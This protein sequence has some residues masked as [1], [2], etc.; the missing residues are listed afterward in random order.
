MKIV[1][2]GGLGYIGSALVPKLAV[3]HQTAEIVV[4]DKRFVPERVADFPYPDRVRFVQGD[5]ADMDLMSKVLAGAQTLYLLAAQVEAETSRE[6]ERAI[7]TDNYELPTQVIALAPDDC[8]IIFPSSANVF[9]GNRDEADTVYPDDSPP[10]PKYPYA[11]T[12][13]AVEGFLHDRGGNYTIVRFGT[14]YGWAPGI[15][16]NLVVNAFVYRAL[17]GLPLTVHGDGTNY[18]PF[19]HTQDCCWAAIHLANLDTAAGQ[20]YHVVSENWQIGEI[21]LEVTER[22]PVPIR[23]VAQPVAFASY[24]MSSEKLLATGFRFTETIPHGIAKLQE[25]FQSVA[26]VV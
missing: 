26:R 25:R 11:E 19:C 13:A 12:K 6:R 15:R 7:W 1:V 24:R 5:M 4:V 22:L 9:G 16:F 18:R 10:Q 14:N 21:A 20:T 23:H 2:L 17:Q 3:K 8:R